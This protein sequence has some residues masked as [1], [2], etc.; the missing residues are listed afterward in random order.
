MFF[1]SFEKSS[2]SEPKSQKSFRLKEQ[3]MLAPCLLA[4]SSELSELIAP[5]GR[6]RKYYKRQLYRETLLK[7]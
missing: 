5:C 2:N 6:S 4:I 1:L 3:F 7:K